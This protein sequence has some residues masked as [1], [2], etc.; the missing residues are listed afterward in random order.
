MG[1]D[2]MLSMGRK[3]KA[4]GQHATPRKPVQLPEDW[5]KVIRQ[6]ASD[7]PMPAVWF[8]IELVKKE[9]EAQGRKDLPP[10]P[11]QVAEK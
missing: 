8:L 2:T 9:A 6:M 10:V 5:L 1:V 3:K 4:S 7:R 11:W